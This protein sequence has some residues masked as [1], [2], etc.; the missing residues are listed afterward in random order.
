MISRP[1]YAVLCAHEVIR[2]GLARPP[3]SLRLT[4]AEEAAWMRASEVGGGGGG[5]DDGTSFFDEIDEQLTEEEDDE[6]EEDD[7][8]EDGDEDG[9]ARKSRRARGRLARTSSLPYRAKPAS[10]SRAKHHGA[11]EAEAVAATKSTT[12]CAS[13]NAVHELDPGQTH[14]VVFI[15]LLSQGFDRWSLFNDAPSVFPYQSQHELTWEEMK[16]MWERVETLPCGCAAK[17]AFY[18]KYFVYESRGS[19]E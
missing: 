2:A 8:D 14:W 11:V 18:P 19:E 4:P 6:E 9:C 15:R 7:D 1:L 3:S 13:C 16:A 10:E 5:D 17:G 12:T